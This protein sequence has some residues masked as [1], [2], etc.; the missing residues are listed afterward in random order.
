LGRGVTMMKGL[1]SGWRA[2]VLMLG[3]GLLA[4]FPAQAEISW[5][6]AEEGGAVAHLPQPMTSTGITGGSLLCREQNWSLQLRTDSD[7]RSQLR[8]GDQPDPLLSGTA[9]IAIGKTRVTLAANR[10]EDV[11]TVA[12][13]YD[14][15]ASIRAGTSLSINVDGDAGPG[16]ARFSLAGSKRVLDAVEPLCSPA[17]IEGHQLVAVSDRDPAIRSA[18]LLRGEDIDAFRLATAS[19]PRLEATIVTLPDGKGILFTRLCGSSWYFGRSGCNVT[20]FVRDSLLGD[21][22]LAYDNEGST[23]HL[24]AQDEAGNWPDIVAMPLKGR[25]VITVWQWDGQAY[26]P[27]PDL[28]ALDKMP[29]IRAQ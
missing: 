25:P 10:S 15:L 14:L 18:R 2:G 8:T 16:E 28:M 26:A 21:W 27:A 3:I 7:W 4:A 22:R 1:L 13:P 12:L 20:G 24:A 9:A 5:Q 17:S 11:I 19:E 29:V 6:Q 23:L